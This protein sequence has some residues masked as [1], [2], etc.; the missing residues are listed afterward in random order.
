[1]NGIGCIRFE[2]GNVYF[3]DFQYGTCSGYGSVSNG[4]AMA[5]KYEQ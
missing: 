1:L 2:D 3:G 5:Y 4:K